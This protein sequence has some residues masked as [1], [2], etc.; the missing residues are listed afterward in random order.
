MS[1]ITIKQAFAKGLGGKAALRSATMNYE[2]TGGR[3]FQRLTFVVQL[4]AGEVR[5]ITEVYP[6]SV[7]LNVAAH[8]LG[9]S[10]AN[11]LG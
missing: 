10:T 8:D 7:N 5:T 3:D 1:M 9:A 6:P 11:D 4:P 2:K